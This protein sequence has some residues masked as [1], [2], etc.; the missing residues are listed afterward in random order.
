MTE[1]A[2]PEDRI[3]LALDAAGAACSAALWRG[4]GVRAARLEPMRRGQSERLVPMIQEVMAE[5]KTGFDE[6]DAV[7][8]TLGPGGFTGVRIG[9]A[10]ARGLALAWRRPVIG[11]SNFLV[12][13]AAAQGEAEGAI[14]VLIDAKRRDL[15]A[16]AF[17]PDLAPLGSPVAVLPEALAA[18]LPEGPLL[19]VGDGV[20][21]ALPALRAAGRDPALS[22]APGL[23]DAADVARL[24]AVAE[25]PPPDRP[26]PGP[27]YL[28]APDVTLPRDGPSG[29]GPSGKGP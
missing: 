24:A 1:R 16:Q 8:T 5:A 25:L 6:L 11:F 19:L 12:L 20:E 13:A 10:T 15:Y 18:Q 22:K 27:L 29:K 21:Q 7:A 14:A 9:L 17:G 2:V 23:S 4:G 3:V 28:R 26:P